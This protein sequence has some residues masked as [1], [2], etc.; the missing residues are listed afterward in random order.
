MMALL[1]CD[2]AI[3]GSAQCWDGATVQIPGNKGALSSSE[4]TAT[5]LLANLGLIYKQR[6]AQLLSYSA[7]L[8]PVVWTNIPCLSTCFDNTVFYKGNQFLIVQ[9]EKVKTHFSDLVCFCSELVEPSD[10]MLDF[11]A[12]NQ[13]VFVRVLCWGSS[14]LNNIF[15]NL[16]LK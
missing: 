15:R 13:A 5:S 10:W 12:Q 8:S 3:T 6:G 7:F 11:P 4:Y 2:R 14:N 16:F 1:P 9:L